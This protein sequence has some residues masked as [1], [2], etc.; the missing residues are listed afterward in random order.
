VTNNFVN[1]VWFRIAKKNNS[2]LAA[3]GFNVFQDFPFRK[4]FT[5][6]ESVD[7]KWSSRFFS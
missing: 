3:C 2:M 7:Q 5:K 4:G 6:L 1:V